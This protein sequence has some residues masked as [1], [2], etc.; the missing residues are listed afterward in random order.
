MC[1]CVCVCVYIYKT[2]YIYIYIYIYNHIH[3]TLA[4]SENS[5][6]AELP[7]IVEAG[8]DGTWHF[9]TTAVTVCLL[10]SMNTPSTTTSLTPLL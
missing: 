8:P 2:I 6:S 10:I 4:R 1:V 5:F 7:G 9:N 3:R